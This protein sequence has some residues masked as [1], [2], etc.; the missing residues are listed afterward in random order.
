MRTLLCV[1]PGR[2]KLVSRPWPEEQPGR[3]R[4]RL[5]RIG[6]CG[7]DYHIFEGSHPYLSYPRVMGHELSGHAIEASRDGRIAAGDLVVINPYLSCGTCRACRAAKP[8]C[9]ENIKVLGVH[10]DGG[11]CEQISVPD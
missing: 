7:T 3:T 1:E 10:T 6:I 8:N 11:M 2:L 5:S 4:V 9:C